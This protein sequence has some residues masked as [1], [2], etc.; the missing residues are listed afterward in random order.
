MI[1]AL[2]KSEM[3]EIKKTIVSIIDVAKKVYI[4]K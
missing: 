3:K 4:E 1:D 2:A